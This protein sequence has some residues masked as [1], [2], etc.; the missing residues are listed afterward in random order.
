MWKKVNHTQLRHRTGGSPWHSKFYESQDFIPALHCFWALDCRDH[1]FLQNG[2]RVTTNLESMNVK[3]KHL[4]TWR[5]ALHSLQIVGVQILFCFSL[6]MSLFALVHSRVHFSWLQ[7]QFLSHIEE[8]YFHTIS[9][10]KLI[11]LLLNSTY[12]EICRMQLFIYIMFEGFEHRISRYTLLHYWFQ[13]F[14]VLR[15]LLSFFHLSLFVYSFSILA[16]SILISSLLQNPGCSSIV[17]HFQ[18]MK[19][20]TKLI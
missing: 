5:T 3:A 9:S 7:T 20:G 10:L 19:S 17:S 6:S 8:T 18:Q 14:Q 4:T 11:T 13:N 2:R 1:S 16:F 15:A 12:L